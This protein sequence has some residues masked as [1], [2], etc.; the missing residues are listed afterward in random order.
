M[1]AAYDATRTEIL[2]TTPAVVLEFN[3]DEAN[4][5]HF[6]E[7]G[8]ATHLL[9]VEWNRT[10]TDSRSEQARDRIAS[11]EQWS[12]ARGQYVRA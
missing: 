2:A 3:V 10:V 6:A 5:M 9:C 12:S 1:D 11:R 8:Q 4:A 7:N